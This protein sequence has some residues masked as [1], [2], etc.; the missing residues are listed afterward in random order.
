MPIALALFWP[1]ITW[2]DVIAEMIESCGMHLLFCVIGFAVR[3]K[4][5]V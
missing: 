3:G 2:A 1:S 5:A 4:F